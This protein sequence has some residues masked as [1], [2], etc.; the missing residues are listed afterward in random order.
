MS[1]TTLNM[2]LNDEVMDQAVP[3]LARGRNLFHRFGVKLQER[4]CP[5]C[6]S[7][8]YTRRHK[9]CGACGGLLP[10]GCR[11]TISEAQNVAR[12]MVAER[13]RH[14]AWLERTGTG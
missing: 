9:L 6:D 13:Q 5:S 10:E 11:F 12:L 2:R 1:A 8:V 4:R 3:I 7:V 14:R